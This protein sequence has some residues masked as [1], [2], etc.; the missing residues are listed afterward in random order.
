MRSVVLIHGVLRG[1][2]QESN[3]EML[4]LKE[5]DSLTRR[6]TYSRCSVIK[7]DSDLPDGEYI[8]AFQSNTVSVRREGSL[9]LADGESFSD[10]A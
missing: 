4:A 7:A 2:G 3:C 1:M 9:W 10:A 8:V 5:T 6:T